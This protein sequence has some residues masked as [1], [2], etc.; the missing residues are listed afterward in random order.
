MFLLTLNCIGSWTLSNSCLS[1]DFAFLPLTSIF[2]FFSEDPMLI[3]FCF[4]FDAVGFLFPRYL[5]FSG[6]FVF[7]SRISALLDPLPQMSTKTTHFICALIVECFLWFI[8]TTTVSL[9]F[10]L[11]YFVLWVLSAFPECLYMTFQLLTSFF[12]VLH[13]I[14]YNFYS[15]LSPRVASN[16][17][18]V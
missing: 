12:P 18:N 14:L 4:F 3:S 16:S 7:Y 8:F 10:F 11:L 6:V 15:G 2:G 1:A 13:Q 9:F 5:D 17:L